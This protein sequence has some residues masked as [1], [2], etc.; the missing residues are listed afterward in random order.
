MLRQFLH[1]NRAA[2]AAEMALVLPAIAF[3]FLNVADL[4]IYMY[5]KMQV[6]LAAQEAVGAARVL[7]DTAAELPATTPGNCPTLVDTM[8]SAAQ[9]TSL[10][11]GVTLGTASEAWYCSTEGAAPRL[12]I[13]API[14][15]P[16]PADCSAE[17]PGSTAKPGEYISVTA[18]YAFA[19]IFPGASVAAVLPNIIEREAWMLLQ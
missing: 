16:R 14:T 13:A 3:I 19:P 4:S 18:S 11:T 12:E 6:D 7:C 8:R 2:A 5:T 15:D 10:G 17:V 1:D 9:S